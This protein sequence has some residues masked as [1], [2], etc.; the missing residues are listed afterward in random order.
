MPSRVMIAVAELLKEM[1]TKQR[2]DTMVNLIHEVFLAV[3]RAPN[4]KVEAIIEFIL[5]A[6]KEVND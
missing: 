1:N 6:S 4:E 5:A 2:S 3:N